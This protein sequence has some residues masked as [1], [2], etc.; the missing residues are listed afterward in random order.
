MP[1]SASRLWIRE[2]RAVFSPELDPA[3]A[4]GGLV[5]EGE[6]IAELLPAGAR[7][8]APVDE[9]LPAERCV[10]IPGLINTHHHFYQTLTRAFGPALNQPL[11]PWLA[12]LYPVW[13]GLT[14]EMIR[15]STELA[16]AELLL[17]GTTTAAD[18]HYVF[19][20]DLA[21]AIDLQVAAAQSLGIRVVLTRGSMSLGQSQ[22]GHPPDSI[23][24]TEDAILEDSVRLL[25]A[26]HDPSPGAMVQIA[27]APCSP[28]SVTRDLLTASAELA[29]WENVLLH[30]HLA[31]T[32]DEEAFCLE[33]TGS[34][35]VEYL[36][37]CGWL[38]D[39]TWFAHGI[40]F[41]AA[42]IE[43][44]GRAGC[45]VSHCPTSNMI[46]S[47]G[48]CPVPELER[49]GVGVSLGVDGSASN[50][51]SNL[52]QEV[53]QALLLQRLRLAGGRSA[54]AEALPTHADALRW[55]TAGGARALRRPELGQIAVGAPADLALF[56]LD[57]PRFS[58]AD[59]P[60]AALVLCGAE[61]A[62]HVFVNGAWRVRNGTIAG[63][64]LERLLARHSE[65]ALA[66]VQRAEG[67]G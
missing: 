60:L 35:P 16:L 4:A 65:L 22:G 14:A 29:A 41:S 36:D 63:L 15:C 28:F 31:E 43:T 42:E 67:V 55:G 25:R 54:E 44:L 56:N 1:P 3:L 57:A 58:G 23:V 49:A 2:P 39:R 40:H 33:T 8:A 64:D 59:D 30:T 62:E 38:T 13:A 6:R 27:L 11:F 45:S 17:S 37:Q 24:Q 12:A 7:P 66:L 5:I 46:L 20:D 53:R 34:R 32:I 26:H 51:C 19:S 9:V 18:H 50:D 61:R 47:S 48:M 21:D 52:M 10:L